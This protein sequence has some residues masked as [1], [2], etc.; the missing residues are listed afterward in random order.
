MPSGTSPSRSATILAI[1]AGRPKQAQRNRANSPS[2]RSDSPN[3][4]SHQNPPEGVLGQFNRQ[5]SQPKR[6]VTVCRASAFGDSP[7]PYTG[8]CAQHR[9]PGLEN[10]WRGAGRQEKGRD[11]NLQQCRSR[12]PRNHLVPGGPAFARSCR[13]EREW[14]SGDYSAQGNTVRGLHRQR[15]LPQTTT[16]MGNG[17]RSLT[18]TYSPS[19]GP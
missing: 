4:A 3:G 5:H 8:R 7:N 12:R 10:E 9:E 14:P 6:L 18:G 1:R 15:L 11:G 17:N 13:D 2:Q 19:L 16:A